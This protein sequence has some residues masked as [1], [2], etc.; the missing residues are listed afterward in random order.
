LV[1]SQ[2]IEGFRP[3]PQINKTDGDKIWEIFPY[4]CGMVEYFQRGLRVTIKLKPQP[5]DAPHG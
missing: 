2:F 3:P 1:G 5:G 4:F